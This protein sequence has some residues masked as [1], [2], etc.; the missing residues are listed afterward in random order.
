MGG[1]GLTGPQIMSGLPTVS[2]SLKA[3]YARSKIRNA[4]I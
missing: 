3:G 1:Q 4:C 2:A